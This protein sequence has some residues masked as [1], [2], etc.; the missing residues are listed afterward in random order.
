MCGL[1]LHAA[2]SQPTALYGSPST[3]SMSKAA[4]TA[5]SASSSRADA[6]SRVFECPVFSIV[7]AEHPNQAFA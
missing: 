1:P 6:I 5:P 3:P 2:V 4:S 7:G